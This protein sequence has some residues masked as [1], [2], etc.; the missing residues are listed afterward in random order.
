LAEKVLTKILFSAIKLC[1]MVN[2]ID[3]IVNIGGFG[4][5]QLSNN[6]KELG[7]FLR[8]ECKQRRQSLR[9]LSLNSGLS[10][11]TVYNMIYRKYRPTVS[12]LN[13]LADYLGIKRQY[14]WRLAGL[15]EDMDYEAETT[16][17]DPQ[18]SETRGD[19]DKDERT[20]VTIAIFQET[21]GGLDFIR[22]PGQSYDGVIQ[23]L[24]ELWKRQLWETKRPSSVEVGQ[25]V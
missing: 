6:K 2:A 7:D 15:L 11:A 16:A 14:L 1:E 19:M 9:G 12:S 17:S 3:N 25:G 24:I 10:A 20:R 23:E 21:K 22:R 5:R 13:H 18:R 4:E 8:S